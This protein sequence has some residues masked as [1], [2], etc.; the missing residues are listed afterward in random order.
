MTGAVRIAVLQMT[1]G[2]DPA[3]NAATIPHAVA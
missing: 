3:A 2:I 1:S